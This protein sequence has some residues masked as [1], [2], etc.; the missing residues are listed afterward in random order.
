MGDVDRRVVDEL[1]HS[2]EEKYDLLSRI[3][4]IYPP[5][6]G[7]SNRGIRMVTSMVH[8]S[9]SGVMYVSPGPPGAPSKLTPT[10]F[11]RM[12]AKSVIPSDPT[13]AT[14]HRPPACE[15]DR[16]AFSNSTQVDSYSNFLLFSGNSSRSS[17]TAAG[18]WACA[19]CHESPAS[20]NRRLTWRR[21]NSWS[22]SRRRYS[23][24]RAELH[25]GA[26]NPTSVGGVSTAR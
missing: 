6:L 22:N 20:F 8:A 4:R 1:Y 11:P 12:A 17:S 10:Y 16:F 23:C 14:D 13:C 15:V 24:A 18:G 5:I 26:S 9:A 19:V 7:R 3:T 2:T 21:E 25:S